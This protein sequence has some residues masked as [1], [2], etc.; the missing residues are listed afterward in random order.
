ML[1]LALILALVAGLGSLVVSHLVTKPTVDTLRT[2]L[3]STQSELDGT[4][5]T[6][7]KTETDLKA[8]KGTLEKTAKE[9]TEKSEALDAVT[10]EATTQKA[11]AEKLATDLAKTTASLKDSQALLA[12]WDAL[13]VKPDQVTQIQADLK[14]VNSEKDALSE[15]KVIFLRNVAQLKAR[16]LRYEDPAAKVELPAGLKGSILAVGPQQDFVLL[17]IGANSGVLERGQL[18]IKRGDKLVGKVQ[19]ITVEPNR[20]IANVLS[21]WKQGDVAVAEGDVVLY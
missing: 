6:L 4:K 9:L 7:A 11:R 18:L 19:V 13:G 14:R 12:Q 10:V 16:L 2:D 1:R 3:A 17:D 20:S 5:Q 21:D 15:E 8:T